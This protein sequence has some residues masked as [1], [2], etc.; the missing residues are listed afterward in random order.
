MTFK[1]ILVKLKTAFVPAEL[2]IKQ[3]IQSEIDNLVISQSRIEDTLSSLLKNVD[4]LC[5]LLKKKNYVEF[6]PNIKTGLQQTI[7]SI[8]MEFAL[9]KKK[10]IDITFSL[11]N[12]D[13]KF[14]EQIEQYLIDIIN[15]NDVYIESK[16]YNA[17]LPG[18]DLLVKEWL[19]KGYME[20]YVENLKKRKEYYHKYKIDD[21]LHL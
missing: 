19:K 18:I 16:K 3:S 11:P 9:Q 8:K 21:V 7:S 15:K 13:I 5:D 12:N 2:K 20:I 4:I 6:S 10:Y 1:E 14:E 17:L